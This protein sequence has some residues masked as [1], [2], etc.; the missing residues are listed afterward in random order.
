MKNVK[1]LWDFRGENTFNMATHYHKHLVEFFES[2]EINLF[3]SGVDKITDYYHLTYAIID[4][5][6][7]NAVK[8]SLKPHRALLVDE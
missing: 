1:L 4:K 6:D 8:Y 7:V 5:I 3:K 2:K